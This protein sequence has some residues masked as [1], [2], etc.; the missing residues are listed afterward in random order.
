ME[1]S[2]LL[3]IAIAVSVP[4]LPIPAAAFSIRDGELSRAVSFFCRS[5]DASPAISGRMRCYRICRDETFGQTPLLA[6]AES[7][8]AESLRLLIEAKCDVDKATLR[9]PSD[10]LSLFPVFSLLLSLSHRTTTGRCCR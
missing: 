10:H 3:P 7:G 8:D 6:A 4:H 2:S 1:E 5:A 9:P